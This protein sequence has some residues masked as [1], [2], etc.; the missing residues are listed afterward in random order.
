MILTVRRLTSREGDAN[1]NGIRTY[2]TDYLVE[3]NS[4]AEPEASVGSAAGL[5]GVG[6]PHPSD[7]TARCN[8]L[9]LKQRDSPF[10]HLWDV[11][12]TYTN[13]PMSPA[14]VAA[15]SPTPT[16]PLTAPSKVSFRSKHHEVPFTEDRDGDPV[17]NS[18]GDAFEPPGNKDATRWTIHIVKNYT[19]IPSTLGDYQDKVND[20]AV[21]LGGL[22]VPD[23]CA[24]INVDGIN[25]VIS[26]GVSYVE[27]SFVIEVRFEGWGQTYIQQGFNEKVGT[28][29]VRKK[30]YIKGVEVT[31]PVPLDATGAMIVDPTPADI[32]RTDPFHPYP[33][34]DFAPLNLPT[35]IW[36]N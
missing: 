4:A 19:A 29:G 32:V 30:C 8:G 15:L 1:E 35:T 16:N 6:S 31:N 33:K 24:K 22:S 2:S 21:V 9:K 20:G 10:S 12:A 27:V 17:V 26:N 3:T 28:P 34:I 11:T 18:A 36:G 5:P 7:P 14:A 23:E 13:E 25:P